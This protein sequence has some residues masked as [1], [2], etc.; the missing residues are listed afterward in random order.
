[1]S[2]DGIQVLQ[3]LESVNL[4]LN[5]LTSVDVLGKVPSLRVLNVS[6]N[7]IVQLDGLRD[8]R[9]LAVLDASF[10]NIT[11]WPRFGDMIT[12]EVLLSRLVAR[13]HVWYALI[14]S[15]FSS[16][17]FGSIK[18]L[19]GVLSAVVGVG[20][21]SRKSSSS[22]HCQESNPRGI[23]VSYVLWRSVHCFALHSD[24]LILLLVRRMLYRRCAALVAWDCTC[25]SCKV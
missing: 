21:V 16:L 2:L 17:V 1:M 25:R 14:P 6:E 22:F 18:Q 10:N 15:R 13:K 5:N 12:L 9:E 24:A 19:A 23:S 11:K 7:S 3:R 4:S 8:H 20:F